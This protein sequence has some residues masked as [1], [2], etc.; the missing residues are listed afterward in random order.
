MDYNESLLEVFPASDKPIT[1]GGNTSEFF[2]G[3]LNRLEGWKTKCKNL[4]WAAPK[5]NIHVYLDDFLEVLQDYQD[6]LAEGYMGILGQMSPNVI[7][8]TPSSVLN[9]TDFIEE[10]RNH[11]LAFYDKIPEETVYKGITSECETFIQNINKY[12]FL[13]SLCDVRPY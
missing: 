2:I 4:H 1:I 3:F 8:G 11:T 13:F 12:K 7:T 10:V 5:K 9:A 6:G